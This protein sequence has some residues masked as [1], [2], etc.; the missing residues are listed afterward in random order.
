L[1]G[2]TSAGMS[3]Q[4]NQLEVNSYRCR[5][6]SMLRFIHA[7]SSVDATTAI[8]ALKDLKSDPSSNFV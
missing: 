8:T 6:V 4:L 2:S 1:R 3:Q 7:I 5:G